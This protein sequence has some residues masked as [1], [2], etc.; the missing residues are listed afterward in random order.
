MSGL[1]GLRRWETYVTLLAVIIGS[2]SSM[3][4]NPK[5]A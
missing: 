2:L 5:P 3:A 4:D 1:V